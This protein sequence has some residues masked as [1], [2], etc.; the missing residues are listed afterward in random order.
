[1]EKMFFLDD[2]DRKLIGRRRGDQHRLGFALQL[3]TARFVGRFLWAASAA[4]TSVL[5]GWPSSRYSQSI[6]QV[7]P[8]FHQ[9]GH[10]STE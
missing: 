9:C 6:S 4:A 2:A 5:V 1:M 8:A 7:S 10:T 3:T